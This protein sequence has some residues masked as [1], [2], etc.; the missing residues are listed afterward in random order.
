MNYVIKTPG[1]TG[2]HRILDYFVKKQDCWPIWNLPTGLTKP[3]D[4]HT[5]SNFVVHDRQNDFFP[6]DKTQWVC[7][8][9]L[10]ENK[11]D[12]MMSYFIA[13]NT[14]E[15]AFYTDKKIE[16]KISTTELELVYARIKDEENRIYSS[17]QD[18]GWYRTE[19]IY[20]ETISENFLKDRFSHNQFKTC[21]L[22]NS[23]ISEKSPRSKKQV[24]SNYDELKDYYTQAI[25]NK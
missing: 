7:V 3:I 2:S 20:F 17:M 24:I 9:S 14:K 6:V 21:D 8:A 13:K 5:Y 12:Q 18:Q 25:A 1:R 19:I 10:R 22:W 11:F 15:F 16:L 23:V 4:Y